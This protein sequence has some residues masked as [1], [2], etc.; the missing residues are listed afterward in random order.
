M[1]MGASGTTLLSLM[2]MIVF[3]LVAAPSL[4]AF[5]QIVPGGRWEGPCPGSARCRH[6]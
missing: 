6:L 5:E 4:N 3:A 1:M 2:A